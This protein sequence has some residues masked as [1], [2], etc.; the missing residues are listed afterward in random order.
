MQ[1]V[2]QKYLECAEIRS[3]IETKYVMEDEI[4]HNESPVLQIVVHDKQYVEMD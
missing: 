2:L 1:P 3:S 4:Q